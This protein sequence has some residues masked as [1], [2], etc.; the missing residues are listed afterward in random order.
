MA[1]FACGTCAILISGV[2]SSVMVAVTGGNLSQALRAGFIAMA[3]AAA[4][5]FV[6]DATAMPGTGSHD[7]P[8][9]S[10]QYVQNVAGHAAVGCLTAVAS[11]GKCGAGAASAAL[12]AAGAPFLQGQGLV[13]GTAASAV[14][15]GLG[16]VAAGGKFAD[17][18][19]TA[20]FGYLFNQMAGERKA[21][22][23]DVVMQCQPTDTGGI[24][25]GYGKV[26]VSGWLWNSEEVV[27]YGDYV[28][29][30]GSGGHCSFSGPGNPDAVGFDLYGVKSEQRYLP[31]SNEFRS[32]PLYTF[33]F[34]VDPSKQ[35]SFPPEFWKAI[36]ENIQSCRTAGTCPITNP[37]GK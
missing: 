9:G 12:G 35:S 1:T 21:C 32:V 20:A 17:G 34:T 19:V 24:N 16:S 4:F 3:T 22:P 25:G 31:F 5:N 33:E 14:L 2:V 26:T 27:K 28:C 13:A 37:R 10:E 7:L 15:G 36:R 8:F 18:A 11:G 30:F 23:V 6:G 29:R